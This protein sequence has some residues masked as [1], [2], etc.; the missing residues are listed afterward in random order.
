MWGIW[1]DRGRDTT[2]CNQRQMLTPDA[3]KSS[4]F[5]L[6][7]SPFQTRPLVVKPDQ[8]P[9][10]LPFQYQLSRPVLKIAARVC[11]NS[12]VWVPIIV[13]VR[14][15]WT[16]WHI[17]SKARTPSGP[18]PFCHHGGRGS[19]ISYF[20]SLKAG[21]TKTLHLSICPLGRIGQCPFGVPA[22]AGLDD[23]A[24]LTTPPK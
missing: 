2:G 11:A 9:F 18:A 7:H 23:R 6:G 5:K 1:T 8:Y 22:G 17:V 16:H 3:H 19:F 12:Q 20:I 15:R 4:Y 24:A 14:A 10:P 21:L 13:I